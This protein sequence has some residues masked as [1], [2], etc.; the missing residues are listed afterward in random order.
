MLF[1]HPSLD[2]AY[3]IHPLLAT[4]QPPKKQTNS[5]SIPTRLIADNR[6]RFQRIQSL[7]SL[8]SIHSILSQ[9]NMT[10][11]IDFKVVKKV[12]KD[13]QEWIG[14]L[15]NQVVSA[16]AAI[17]AV[18][19]NGFSLVI[20]AMERKWP[21]IH[22]FTRQLHEEVQCH[23]VSCNLYLTPKARASHDGDRDNMRRSGFESHWDYM[24]V[25][26]LQLTGTKL[27]T[28]AN[29]P[30][31]YLSNQDEKRKPTL[32]ELHDT[33]YYDDFLL[34]PGDALYIPRGFI[35]NAS[36]VIMG[37]SDDDGIPSLHLTFGLEHNCETTVE[38]LLHH[39]IYKFAVASAV[40][41]GIAISKQE[42][43]QSP[44][45]V[46]WETILHQSL[47][48]VARRD[49]CETTASFENGG[50]RPCAGVLRQ[51][52][53]LH[54]AFQEIRTNR[55]KSLQQ[56]QFKEANI[57]RTVY[58]EALE[59]FVKNADVT[60]LVGFTNQLFASQDLQTS[61]CFPFI[62]DSSVIICPNVLSSRD[63]LEYFNEILEQF[64]R[65]A[66]VRLESV[67]QGFEGHV[68]DNR[69]DF[70]TMNDAVLQLVQQDGVGDESLEEL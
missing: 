70:W 43:S 62:N 52:V 16:D 63:K 46:T 42:C 59:L 18:S 25:I 13:G 11:G 8:G 29:E 12:E 1:P 64:E 57:L 56:N 44:H 66:I 34:Q 36:T 33:E 28:V 6:E 30:I 39:A 60:R 22:T 17:H 26:V 38:A 51:S 3:E 68:L 48:E 47:S 54:P 45:N 14:M 40:P 50:R 67:I 7:F 5:T 27:W 58:R 21:A 41:N 9:E 15:P 2:E 32:E 23:V 61:F 35:H 31:V 19:H 24:D 20:D 55:Q 69:R 37:Q 53:P 49:D 10:H 4:V 65:F